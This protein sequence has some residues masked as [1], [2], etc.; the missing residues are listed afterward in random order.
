[1]KISVPTDR[2]VTKEIDVESVQFLS[3]SD[4]L[5]HLPCNGGDKKHAIGTD[6]P[7]AIVWACGRGWRL[8]RKCSEHLAQDEQDKPERP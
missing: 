8:C 3:P 1:M 6:R 5:S 7:I 4:G 2:F